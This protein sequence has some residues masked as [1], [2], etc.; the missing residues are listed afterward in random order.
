LEIELITRRNCSCLS[1]GK[2]ENQKLGGVWGGVVD[3]WGGGAKVSSRSALHSFKKVMQRMRNKLKKKSR[4]GAVHN[5]Q[6]KEGGMNMKK[7]GG[8]ILVIDIEGRKL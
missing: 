5:F 4:K 8:R 3:N 6:R 7:G 1:A 2:V